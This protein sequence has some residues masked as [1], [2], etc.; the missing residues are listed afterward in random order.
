MHKNNDLYICRVCGAEQLEAP[1]GDD[2]ESPTYEICD[3]CGVE[4]GYEDSTLQGIKKYRTKWLEDGA[5]WHSKKSEPENWSVVE[6]LSHIP[7]KYLQ[8]SIPISFQPN[9]NGYYRVDSYNPATGEIVSR[10]F[11]QFSDITESTATNYIREA[12]NKCP[13]GAT[14]AKVPSSG[15]LGGDALRGTNILEVPPQVKPIPQSVF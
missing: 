12:V 2:G 1:W 4:F 7:E 14:I 5:K 10:K 13:A 6:Q 3:C 8:L 11:T 15:S 9:G